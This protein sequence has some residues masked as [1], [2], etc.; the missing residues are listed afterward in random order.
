[1]WLH[2]RESEFSM[3]SKGFSL[4][5]LMIVVVIVGLLAAIFIPNF[6]VMQQNGEI[7]AE[8]QHLQLAVESYANDN[9]GQS[10]QDLFDLLPY[11]PEGMM[12]QNIFSK[13]RTEPQFGKAA[14]TAGQIGIEFDVKHKDKS[15]RY[16]ITARNHDRQILVLTDLS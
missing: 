9:D 1:M 4:L 3:F 14:E 7:R 11:L 12:L 16:K 13:K 5:E 10:P 6:I 8:A 15:V 2:F